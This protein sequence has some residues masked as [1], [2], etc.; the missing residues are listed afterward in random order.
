MHPIVA[1]EYVRYEMQRRLQ[2]A[3]QRRLARQVQQVRRARGTAPAGPASWRVAARR[4][5][6]SLRGT[7]VQPE[8]ARQP[9]AAHKARAATVPA[10]A[11]SGNVPTQTPHGTI[12]AQVR[13]DEV[14]APAES[15]LP[16]S[17]SASTRSRDPW[18]EPETERVQRQ[19]LLTAGRH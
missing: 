13:R 2:D 11:R 6:R 19:L 7:P 15:R 9:E 16:R 3:E 8:A 1:Q 17:R 5:L 4:L 14:N 12:P 18:Q 10:Q